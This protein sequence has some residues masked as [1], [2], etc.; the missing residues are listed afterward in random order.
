MASKTTNVYY[1]VL[2]YLWPLKIYAFS[3]DDSIL[4]YNEAKHS[5]LVLINILQASVEYLNLYQDAYGKIEKIKN[6]TE[7]IKTIMREHTIENFII[8]HFDNCMF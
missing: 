7:I 6:Y 5:R 4:T 2:E 8:N 1:S 3:L